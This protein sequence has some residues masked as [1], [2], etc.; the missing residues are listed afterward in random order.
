MKEEN[1]ILGYAKR[2]ELLEGNLERNQALEIKKGEVLKVTKYSDTTVNGVHT[3]D[4]I[5]T[6]EIL[7]IRKGKNGRRVKVKYIELGYE[8]TFLIDESKSKIEK[9]N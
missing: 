7:G 9:I 8:L 4:E 3:Y 6:Y 1:V 5:K 2:P